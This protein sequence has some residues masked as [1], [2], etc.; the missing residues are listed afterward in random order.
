MKPDYR[1]TSAPEHYRDAIYQSYLTGQGEESAETVGV[2]IGVRKAYCR[3][4]IAEFFP[5][6][7][8]ASILELACGYGA[9]IHHAR[10]AGYENIR[11]V[12]ISPEQVAAAHR[13]GVANVTQ[14]DCF[15]A[16]AKEPNE[17]LDAVVSLDLIEH[18]SKPE[19]CR[20]AG[21]IARVLKPTGRWIIHCPNGESPFCGSVRY[22]DFTHELC[23]TQH[24]LRQLLTAYRFSRIECFEDGPIPHGFTSVVRLALWRTIHLTLRACMVIETGQIG[25]RPIFTQNLFCVAY[26]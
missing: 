16:L 9:L 22:G 6:N 2:H 13:A 24:S 8:D 11:G 26:K 15:E 19:L 14:A 1:L 12:D 20:L 23:F 4:I 5:P 10:V 18:F 3:R 7:R 25:A 17:N 21:E